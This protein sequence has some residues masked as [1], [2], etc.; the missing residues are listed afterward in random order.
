MAGLNCATPSLVAWPLTSR[1]IDVHVA[2]GDERVPG[3]MRLLA[4]DGIVAGET[5]AA[6][7]AG[8]AFL[9]GQDDRAP[10]RPDARVLLIVTEGATDPDAYARLVG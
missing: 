5:G 8:M 2:I 1:G 4:Q 7:L 6:G 9:A 3:A 10:L